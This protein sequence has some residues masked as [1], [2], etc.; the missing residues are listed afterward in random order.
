[1]HYVVYLLAIIEGEK[2]GHGSA[3]SSPI[4]YDGLT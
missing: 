1:M 4:I 3:P 2:D